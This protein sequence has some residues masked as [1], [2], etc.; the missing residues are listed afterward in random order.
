MRLQVIHKNDL[1]L[2][3][4]LAALRGNDGLCCHWCGEEK[5]AVILPAGVKI[6]PVA[7]IC[8]GCARAALRLK[9]R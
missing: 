4:D 6:L 3:S 2:D 5:D 9:S 1:L 8:E 7:A